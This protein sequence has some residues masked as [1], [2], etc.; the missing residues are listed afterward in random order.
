M[1]YKCRCLCGKTAYLLV[2]ICTIRISMVAKAKSEAQHVLRLV[3][4]YDLSYP[5]Y[6]DLEENNVREKL[7][8][9]EIADIAQAFCD[10]I[11]AA[12]Y[13]VAIYA[14]TDWF[15]NYLTDS[16]FAQWDKW[17]CTV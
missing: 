12:G 2:H 14:N 16:R 3:E 10:I 13:E 4:G 7:S 6:Y 9:K 17:G 15:T 1:V 5:I 11:E 8:T